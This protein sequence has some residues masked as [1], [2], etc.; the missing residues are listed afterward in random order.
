MFTS[1]VTSAIRMDEAKQLLI[2]HPE[3]TIYEV[4]ERTGFAD[5]AH[6]TRAFTRLF[7]T[8]PSGMREKEL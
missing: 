4:A 8:T 3:L 2:N 6:F 5:N 7:G 1:A